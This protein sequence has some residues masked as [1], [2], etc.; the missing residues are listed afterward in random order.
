MVSTMGKWWEK[1]VQ[2]LRALLEKVGR[3]GKAT[4]EPAYEQERPAAYEKS[5]AIFLQ[6]LGLMFLV[7][8]S[9]YFIQFEGLY[10]SQGILPLTEQLQLSRG[11]RWQLYP[12][13]VRW[14]AAL[15]IDE[16]LLCNFLAVLG[17]L[18]SS[19]AAIGFGTAPVI[20]ACCVLYLSLTT[21]GDV[22][23]YFQWDALLLETGFLS[24][25]Y[26]PLWT[27]PRRSSQVPRVPLWMLRFL[28]FKL[29]LMS[30]VVKIASKDRVW[31]QLTALSYHFASQPI[32]TPMA[33]YLRQL[34]P[35]LLQ[36]GVA[37][38]FVIEIPVAFLLICPLR[39]VRH[40]AAGAV[41]LLQVLIMVSGNYG[42]FNLL[43]LLLLVNLLDD[44]FWVSFLREWE[45]D[46]SDD[47]NVRGSGGRGE[48]TPLLHPGSKGMYGSRGSNTS[49]LGSSPSS[50]PGSGLYPASMRGSFSRGLEG[51][52]TYVQGQTSIPFRGAMGPGATSTWEGRPLPSAGLLY[53]NNVGGVG[54]AQPSS[55][56]FNARTAQ[57]DRGLALQQLLGQSQ[58]VQAA[59]TIMTLVTSVDNS[60]FWSSVVSRATSVCLLLLCFFMFR[61]D[62][63]YARHPVSVEVLGAGIDWSNGRYI[64]SRVWRG[65]VQ[66]KKE[67]GPLLRMY[68]TVV[69]SVSTWVIGAKDE[70]VYFTH[71]DSVDPPVSGWQAA[72]KAGDPPPSIRLVWSRQGQQRQLPLLD[73]LH[74]KLAFSPSDLTAFL[75]T[76]LPAVFLL[77]CTGLAI[78][79]G[80]DL[81]YAVIYGL[82]SS[83][84]ILYS[85]QSDRWH[86]RALQLV[87]AWLPLVGILLICLTSAVI[88]LANM[89]A[90]SE[91]A[92][93]LSSSLLQSPRSPSAWRE[94]GRRRLLSVDGEALLQEGAAEGLSGMAYSILE[95]FSLANSYG[96]FRSMTGV[97]PSVLDSRGRV[98]A[99]VTRPELVI[100]VSHGKRC[101]EEDAS[102]A[103]KET[104]LDVDNPED[105]ACQWLP[106]EFHFKPGNIAR[107]PP[108]VAP[109]HPRLDWQMWF[110]ALAY[111]WQATRWFPTFLQKLVQQ[112]KP[113]VELV[114]RHGIPF[115]SKELPNFIRVRKLLYDFTVRYETTRIMYEVPKGDATDLGRTCAHATREACEEEEKH[116]EWKKGACE[117]RKSEQHKLISEQSP[118]WWTRHGGTLYSPVLKLADFK[119]KGYLPAGHSL[120][121]MPLSLGQELVGKRKELDDACRKACKNRSS[122]VAYTFLPSRAVCYLKSVSSPVRDSDCTEDCWYYGIVE[123]HLRA[124][125][126]YIS[127]SSRERV[128]YLISL[129]V[130]FLLL[131]R[132]PFFRELDINLLQ[133][134]QTLSSFSSRQVRLSFLWLTS[135]AVILA[136]VYYT[137]H[138]LGQ[139]FVP[140]VLAA[141]SG[142][143]LSCYLFHVETNLEQSPGYSPSCDLSDKISC[144]KVANSSGS[145]LFF[146]T[147]NSSFGIMFY[148][149]LIALA[150]GFELS[151]DS[152]WVLMTMSALALVGLLVSVYLLYLSLWVL[153]VVCPVCIALHIINLAIWFLSVYITTMQRAFLEY[154]SFFLE[155]MAH[156][157]KS[158][159]GD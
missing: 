77:F 97:G 127:Q 156:S 159:H 32:P 73:R 103:S 139:V 72:S 62:L 92:P 56:S 35:L 96:L 8:F 111:D 12:T 50:F 154:D 150:L 153:R 121:D 55:R 29:M 78:E 28:L 85:S 116:C 132:A 16:Y 143:L 43:T 31:Q 79:S 105:V 137:A 151:P 10:G 21:V 66:Y 33:W 80:I 140:Y 24:V 124:K 7:A 61:V 27:R 122:C 81:S 144:S 109:Y 53:S 26:A 23:M 37:L 5:R 74:I 104:D 128:V 22:F 11:L 49:Y 112:S 142:M 57:M 120:P 138:H 2:R 42:F 110:A 47:R 58:A 106:F 71:S 4:S 3:Q 59:T 94:D 114:G 75:N 100:E 93:S 83:R 134:P 91:I 52:A 117:H 152:Y 131:V 102:S 136:V 89:V 51:E 107:A 41:A 34:H 20:F 48:E 158:T 108:W 115:T 98:M 135:L 125:Y 119:G 65:S 147:H 13:I 133:L 87:L 1:R 67:S 54:G 63:D 18:V 130:L 141:G 46:A 25:M 82:L 101:D 129:L 148:F 90:M 9:S 123:E 126:T 69:G 15:G 39:V 30:G 6:G 68:K 14:H 146:R 19:I 88:I 36:L 70:A 45:K 118:D 38:V 99:Q 157:S 40:G 64:A 145:R 84:R 60:K 95:P 86:T 44:T 149:F 76:A 155:A 113:V 17:L